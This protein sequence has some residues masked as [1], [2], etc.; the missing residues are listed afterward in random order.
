MYDSEGIDVL[1]L[2]RWSKLLEYDFFRLYSQHIILYAPPKGNL[3][4]IKSSKS[5]MPTF[6]KNIYTIE[7]IDF[8]IELVN[9]GKKTKQEII[10]QYNIPKTTL[11]KWLE[12]YNEKKY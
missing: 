4:S 5:K 2:L 11:Y 6:R 7:L 3:L 12:K 10:D 1:D 8:I 9:T